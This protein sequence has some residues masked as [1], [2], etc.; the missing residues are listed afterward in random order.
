[1][2]IAICDNPLVRSF[3]I[4]RTG[5]MEIWKGWMMASYFWKKLCVAWMNKVWHNSTLAILSF[6]PPTN[7]PNPSLLS[8]KKPPYHEKKTISHKK[9]LRCQSHRRNMTFAIP[10][11]LRR[12]I[13]T[14]FYKLLEF[15]IF[16]LSFLLFFFYLFCFCRC[17][18]LSL[19]L[20]IGDEKT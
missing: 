4:L 10:S 11:V 13:D 14:F 20:I 5:W 18:N 3:A 19:A 7:M 9:E 16:T 12:F 17:H 6:Q 15:Y 8:K 2:I 1:M